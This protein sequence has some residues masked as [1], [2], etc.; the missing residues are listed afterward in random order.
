MEVEQN[1]IHKVL[2]DKDN[3]RS[4]GYACRKGLSV[5]HYQHHADRLTTPLKRV[6]GRFEAVSWDQALDEI[7]ERLRSVV[8]QHGPR[9]LAYMGGGGQGCHLEA[10]FAVRLLRGL[11]SQYHYSAL[12]QELTGMF[13]VHGRTFGRQYLVMVPDDHETDMLLAIGWNGWMSHQMPQARRTLK[14]IADDP[15][16]LLVV[17]DPRKSELAERANIHLAIRP[18]TDALLTRAM[19]A[20][21]L[22]EKWENAEYIEKH[23]KDFEQI[24]PWF[25]DFD[26]RAAVQVCQLDFDEVR[27][28][29]KLFATR[30]SSLHADLGTLMNR[31]STV[32]S[33]LQIVL[34]A[35][36]GRLGVPGGNLFPGYLMPMGAHS[37]ERKPKAWRTVTTDFPAIMGTY[38]PNVMPEEIMSDHP[39]RLRAVLVSGANPLRSYADTT[40]Y[41]NAFAKLDLLVTVDVAFTETAQLSHYVL[42]ARS[43]YEKWDGTFFAWTHPEVFFQLRRPVVEPEGEPLEES[44]IYVRLAERLGMVPEIP[45]ELY[46]AA[47]GDRMQ[48]GAA[49][50]GYGQSEPRAMPMMPYILAKTLGPTLGSNNLAA[51]WGLLQIAPGSFR[52]DAARAGFDPGFTMGNEIFQALLDH[53]EGV[54][55]AK[56]SDENNLEALRTE[57][58]RLEL[59]IPELEDW[60]K[61]VTPDSEEA[62]LSLDANFPLILMAGRHMDENANTIMRDPAWNAGRPRPGALTMHSADARKLSLEDGQM[63]RVTT[64]AG[65]E[66]VELRITDSCRPGH[67]S[68]PHGFGLV[69]QGEK[70][71]ANVNRLT[72]NTHRDRLAATPLH[73]FVPCR[74]EAA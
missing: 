26:A 65:E 2:P 64:E 50:M 54:W 46:E 51:L 72:K 13:W 61:S 10:A 56:S 55:I 33:Y 25:T 27:E 49:L 22:Q 11:G 29:C 6:D 53:P 58:R 35:L 38:P 57:S 21:I 66:L 18:G 44:E 20:I 37:D 7:A 60:V 5:A 52:K 68:I 31:H 59:F 12:A 4:E 14:A 19:I 17:I 62:D 32:A 42:P 67:V 41:E 45:Q 34:L 23:T 69:F 24:L 15:N 36:C 74:V 71:G 39:E 3:P 70:W 30:K 28:V 40:A 8:G 1:R 47:R 9:S 16:R 73:K 43:A 63:V 48:F